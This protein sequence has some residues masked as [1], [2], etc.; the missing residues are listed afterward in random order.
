MSF[1]QPD[2]PPQ[3]NHRSDCGLLTGHEYQHSLTRSLL[4]VPYWLGNET[5]WVEAPSVEPLRCLQS[6]LGMASH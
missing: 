5:Q 6:H 2:D 3:L 1:A 4:I